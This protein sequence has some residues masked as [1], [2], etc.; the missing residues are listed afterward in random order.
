MDIE[1]QGLGAGSYPTPPEQ[2][3]RTIEIKI[4]VDYVTEIEVPEDWD[5]DKIKEDIKENL[6][7]YISEAEINDWEADYYGL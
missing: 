4:A 5:S 1:T 3:T 6:R 2:R 7:E